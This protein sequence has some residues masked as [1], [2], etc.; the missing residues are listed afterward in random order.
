MGKPMKNNDTLNPTDPPV[1]VAG[2]IS[3]RK[4]GDKLLAS[5]LKRELEHCGI[6]IQFLS[7]AKEGAPR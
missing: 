5:I 2:L 7:E 1:L 3:A 4:S 6:K